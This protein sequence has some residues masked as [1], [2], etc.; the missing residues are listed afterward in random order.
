M[1]YENDVHNTG[2]NYFTTEDNDVW[3]VYEIWTILHWA[4]LMWP[5]WQ[6]HNY[7]WVIIAWYLHGLQ[8]SIITY[9]CTK[10][11]EALKCMHALFSKCNLVNI[12]QVQDKN[13]YTM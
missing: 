10:I 5:K 3:T 13:M 6:K 7:N 1:T 4:V 11:Y 9:N 12:S 8:K 2:T